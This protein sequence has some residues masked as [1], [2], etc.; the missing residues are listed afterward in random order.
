M[1]Q[2]RQPYPQWIW[3]SGEIPTGN[4]ITP[5]A[6]DGGYIPNDVLS[7]PTAP[8]AGAEISSPDVSV[9]SDSTSPGIS[10]GQDESASFA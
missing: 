9:D 4:G 5:N 2:T 8:D 7:A 6:P 3:G 10:I 1:H